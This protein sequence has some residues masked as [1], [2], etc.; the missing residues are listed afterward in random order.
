VDAAARRGTETAGVTMRILWLTP[1]QL[2][3]ATGRD[4]TGGGWL[5]GLRQALEAHEPSV[6]LTIAS[7]GSVRHEPFR[8]GNAQYLRISANEP[9][10]RMS[11][12]L[13]RWVPPDA[14]N[15]AVKD[16]ER[17][18]ARYR[19]H[20]I[21]V[22]GSESFLGLALS[23]TDVPSLISLQGIIHAYL[24]HAT[25]G[26]GAADW[27]RLCATSRTARGFGLPQ[28]LSQYRAR[29]RTELDIMAS[30][31]AYLGRT[32][33]DRA[34]LR[35]VRPD[36]RYYVAQEVLNQVF[37][38]QEWED[39]GHGAP[40][41][42][43]SGASPLKG[44]DTLLDA[45]IILRRM[46][47]HSTRLRVAG[48]VKSG[49]MWPIVSRK[50]ASPWLRGTVDLLG[51]LE[52]PAIAKEFRKASMFVHPSHIDNS[53]NALCEAM[54]AGLPC[55]ASFVG[56]VPSLVK[57]EDSGLLVHDREPAMLASAIDRL[58]GD[59]ALASRLG[60]RARRVACD[61]HDPKRV[62][63]SVAEIYR[64]VIRDAADSHR[65]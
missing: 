27:L 33:W 38:D 51:V 17:I 24:P 13:Q 14:P 1:V 35:A 21:H 6:E 9:A 59:R 12:I 22:H 2:P 3:A 44:L 5:E 34:V 40:L 58:L 10:D 63:Q 36:A 42:C 16:C 18:I 25:T 8:A 32:E 45:L 54:L 15:G 50:L 41:F 47:G 52:P 48:A 28:T 31:G 56:G 49:P 4:A 64:E 23:G 30:C 55:V 57:H 26:L 46:R 39:P 11:R 29:A 20:L 61:R 19:P 65:G 37:Y 43:T 60:G 62:A 53:P 7:W